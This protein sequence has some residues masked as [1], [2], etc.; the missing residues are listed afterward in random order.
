MLEKK[1]T[2]IPED[3]NGYVD[4]GGVNVVHCITHAGVFHADDV[5]STALIKHVCNA[6]SFRKIRYVF[7]RVNDYELDALRQSISEDGQHYIIYDIGHGEFDHHQDNAP[8]REGDD[9]VPYAAFGRLWAH[10]GK[11][12]FHDPE[13]L[14]EID[15]LF[16]APIDAQDN[17]IATNPLSL[18][19]KMMNPNWNEDSRVPLHFNNAVQVAFDLLSAIISNY[20]AK[21]SAADFVKNAVNAAQDGVMVLDKFAPYKHYT[22]GNPDI[23]FVIY[24]S[25]RNTDWN[26]GTIIT[27][28]GDEFSSKYLLPSSWVDSDDRYKPDGMTFCHKARF[29]AAFK[30]KEQALA[31]AKIASASCRNN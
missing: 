2:N 8:V 12:I 11:N 3:E 27:A 29:I 6:Y 31:A 15:Q 10:Y 25:A 16:V 18:V 23:D 4:M 24:P 21:L 9:G 17:G 28:D 30:T 13:T 22:K 7:H 19:I 20:R 26:I 1:T 5:F 14:T